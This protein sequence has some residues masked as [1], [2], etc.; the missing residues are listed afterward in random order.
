MCIRDSLWTVFELVV[1]GAGNPTV[2]D[3]NT[4]TLVGLQGQGIQ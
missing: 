4:I 3:V 1:D 2:R